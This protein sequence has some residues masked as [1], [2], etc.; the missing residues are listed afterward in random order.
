M[1]VLL[2]RSKPKKDLKESPCFVEWKITKEA[3]KYHIER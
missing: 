2:E 1:K 3:I